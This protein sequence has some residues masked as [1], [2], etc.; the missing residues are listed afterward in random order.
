MVEFVSLAQAF[1]LPFAVIV[2]IL[3]AWST[4][5]FVSRKTYQ[6]TID[7]YESRLKERDGHAAELREDRNF[8]RGIFEATAGVVDTTVNLLE[9]R[10]S[11]EGQHGG[12]NG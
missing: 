1:G 10:R 11:T 12:R 2:A 6:R 5:L 4:D 9:R 3:G 8:Y 7:E